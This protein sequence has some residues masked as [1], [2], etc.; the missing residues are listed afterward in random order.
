MVRELYPGDMPAPSQAADLPRVV[1]VNKLPVGEVVRAALALLGLLIGL[2]LLWRIQ[3]VLFLLFVAVLLATAIEP[4]VN[5]LRRGPF[6]RGSGVLV[7]YSAIVLL[8]SVVGY[9]VV[10]SV[11]SQGGAFTETLPQRV[12]AL[13]AQAENLRPAPLRDAATSAL[14]RA[15]EATRTP[16]APPG[17]QL[18]AVG[19]TAAHGIISFLTVF[20]LAFYWLVERATIK[21]ALLRAVPVRHAR[22]VN[23]VWL[24]VEEKL[25][26]WVRGQLLLMLAV[27]V[28]AGLGYL[29]IGLPN[30]AVLAVAAGLFEIVPMIGP[31]LAFTPA[32]L[33]A[34]ATD[35]T[36]ALIVVVYAVI[37]Q[38]IESQVLVPRVMRHAVG[39]SPL[40]V[41]LGILAGAALA[42]LAGAFLAVPLAAAAQVILAHVLRVEDPAQAEEHPTPRERAEA[43]S[44][45]GT[46]A[47]PGS[48]SARAEA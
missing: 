28:M 33:V 47:S 12:E 8:L 35:P 42:G 6:T 20:V 34:L 25:G 36:K 38:Q 37:I 11:A 44:G 15:V 16:A 45:G 21:R 13:Q 31:V 29:V 7:V 43:Q 30:P 9:A 14:A 24:E 39:V 46:G 10:P 26:G 41:L 17:E 19:E 18:V 48:A 23:T 1:V 22:S 3:E 27:G 32:V 4:I 40:T 2:Y 5:R